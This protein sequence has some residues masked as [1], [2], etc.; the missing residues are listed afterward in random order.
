MN[1]RDQAGGHGV[2]SAR[3]AGVERC[4]GGLGQSLD[5]H[6]FRFRRIIRSPHT[7]HLVHH[8][9]DSGSVGGELLCGQRRGRKAA[10]PGLRGAAHES[11]RTRVSRAVRR[12]STAPP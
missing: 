2:R 9:Q 8:V 10:K 3:Q 1:F 7:G 11:R 6:C 12:A 4:Q 5:Q